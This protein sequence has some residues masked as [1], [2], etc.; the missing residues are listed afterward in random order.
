MCRVRRIDAA[1]ACS[2]SMTASSGCEQNC[3]NFERRMGL[4]YR[5]NNKTVLRTGFGII[6]A[7]DDTDYQQSARWI[8]QSPD[9]VEYS[10]ATVDRIN[11][12]VTCRAAFRR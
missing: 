4:P 7:E 5:L 9:F 1:H 3:H 2:V 11:P 8:N 6:F 12:L 10:L